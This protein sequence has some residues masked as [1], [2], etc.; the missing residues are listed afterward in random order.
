MSLPPPSDIPRAQTLRLWQRFHFRLT[1]LYG[2]VVLVLGPEPLIAPQQV[3]LLQP[4][5]P[6]RSLH[7]ATDGL[8]PFAVVNAP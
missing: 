7:V 8:H 5:H 3:T 2:G 4:A 6:E 1:V